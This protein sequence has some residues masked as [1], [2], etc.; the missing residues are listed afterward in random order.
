M[1]KVIVH[2]DLNAFFVR[3]E[4]IKNP[5]LENKAVAIGQIGRAHV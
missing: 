2:I 4:E 1:S 5:D 3:A